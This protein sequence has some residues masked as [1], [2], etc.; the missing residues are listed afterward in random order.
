[1]AFSGSVTGGQG[2]STVM[3]NKR[4]KFGTYTNA[5]ADSGGA[6]TTGLSAIVACGVYPTSHVDNNM[7]KFTVS[8]GIITLVTD[9]GQDGNWWAIGT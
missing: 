4:W 9:N 8:G 7:P 5:E 1:M 6:I 3:G 2:G